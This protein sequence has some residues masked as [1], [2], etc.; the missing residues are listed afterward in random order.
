MM[1]RPYFSGAGWRSIEQHT[2]TNAMGSD[3][4]NRHES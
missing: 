2:Q 4:E 1:G 3:K